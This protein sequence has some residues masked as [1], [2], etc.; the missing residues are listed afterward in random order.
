MAPRVV[1][2]TLWQI[3]QVSLT[4][5]VQS[6]F[7]KI[8]TIHTADFISIRWHYRPMLFINDSIYIRCM[9]T[10]SHK[11]HTHAI[12]YYLMIAAKVHNYMI[13]YMTQ[14]RFLKRMINTLRVLC[15]R[16]IYDFVTMKFRS[17]RDDL[18]DALFLYYLKCFKWYYIWIDMDILEMNC[19]EIQKA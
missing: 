1:R 13:A 2:Q 9:Y 10:R 5:G 17:I 14:T 4:R 19:T 12:S 8:D 11:Q 16:M 6:T 7:M 18:L 3:L 15:F